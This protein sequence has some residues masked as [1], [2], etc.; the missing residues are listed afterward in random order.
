[1]A[2]QSNRSICW[3]LCSR[4]SLRVASSMV[5]FV[6]EEFVEC[7]KRGDWRPQLVRDVGEKVSAAV[8]VATDEFD[9]VLQPFGHGVERFS[10]SSVTS[11]DALGRVTRVSRW[12]SAS[13]RAALVSRR[14]GSV[15]RSAM[16]TE[17]MSAAISARMARRS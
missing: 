2:S 1:M 3:R 15:R 9:R 14:M 5:G 17:A 6:G 7:P 12:P 16:N 13:S 10:E 11:G 8:T 4:N